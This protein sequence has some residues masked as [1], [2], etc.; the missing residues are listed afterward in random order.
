MIYRARSSDSGNIGHHL[1]RRYGT[2]SQTSDSSELWRGALTSGGWMTILACYSW[3][4]G[5]RRL[6]PIVPGFCMSAPR[7]NGFR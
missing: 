2:R 1:R 7:R 6:L 3:M 5:S 4:A